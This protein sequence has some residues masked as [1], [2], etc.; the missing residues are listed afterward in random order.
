MVCCVVAERHEQQAGPELEA[1]EDRAPAR[2]PCRWWCGPGAGRRG[3]GRRPRCSRASSAARRRPGSRCRRRAAPSRAPTSRRR[4]RPTPGSARTNRGCGRAGPRRRPSR[5][6]LLEV[7]PARPVAFC[8]AAPSARS[9][10]ARVHRERLVGPA[11]GDPE[12]REAH[13]ASSVATTARSRRGVGR[14]AMAWTRE[15]F[16]TPKTVARR[17]PAPP[18]T[19]ISSGISTVRRPARTCTSPPRSD[20][21]RRSVLGELRHEEGTV[22]SLER[23]LVVARDDEH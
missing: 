7:R 22:P 19:P 4:S 3:S 6:R 14:A 15:K 18:P 11:G 5:S 12:G 2:W 21:A 1:G 17:A 16:A 13:R 20:V 23:D 8:T 9:I 10:C